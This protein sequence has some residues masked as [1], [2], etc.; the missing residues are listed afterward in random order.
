[1]SGPRF[2]HEKF[3]IRVRSRSCNTEPRRSFL[4]S[5]RLASCLL[6]YE[7][8]QSIK[9]QFTFRRNMSPPSLS[10]KNKWLLACNGKIEK[11]TSLILV[12]IFWNEYNNSSFATM[13]RRALLNTCITTCF[14]LNPSHHQVLSYTEY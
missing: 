10:S 5:E 9:S 8:V 7:T 12:V 6:G 1:V 2:E 13:F 14:G 3:H 11:Q 4:I